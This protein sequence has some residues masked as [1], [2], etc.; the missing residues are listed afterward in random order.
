MAPAAHRGKHVPNVAKDGIAAR[1]RLD[2]YGR[3][4]GGPRAISKNVR[5][6][7]APV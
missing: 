5:T 4:L 3:G 7:G 6:R 2:D 1:F